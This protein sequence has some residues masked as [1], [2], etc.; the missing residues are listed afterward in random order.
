M[1]TM[2]AA[3]QEKFHSVDVTSG[4]VLLGEI[5]AVPDSDRHACEAVQNKAIAAVKPK[6]S[7]FLLNAEKC[8]ESWSEK[9]A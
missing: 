9:S 8:S 4:F 1:L 5:Q 7:S 6:T 3:A 2:F